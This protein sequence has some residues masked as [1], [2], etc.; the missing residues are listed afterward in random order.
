MTTAWIYNGAFA[1]LCR[2]NLFQQ[3]LASSL[4]TMKSTSALC[5]AL[6]GLSHAYP[7][8]LEHLEQAGAGSAKVKRQ[9][10]LSTP[11]FDAASQYVDTTGSHA[12]QAPG[13][14]DQ[15]GPCP[16]LN[17]LANVSDN[18]DSM[19]AQCQLTCI[20]SAWLLAAQWYRNDHSIHRKHRQGYVA[21]EDEASFIRNITKRHWQCSAWESTFPPFL[22]YT[23]QP[24]MAMASNGRL[25]DRTAV[26]VSQ[27]CWASPRVYQ[28]LT[29]STR[30]TARPLV[31]IC[32]NV[33]MLSTS[34]WNYSRS[35]MTLVRR[36]T[37]MTCNCSRTAA[38]PVPS[39]VRMKTLTASS[40]L[41]PV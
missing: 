3:R 26:S 15:R 16:G 30:E 7:N 10:P 28:A 38:L 14:T 5:L 22:P 31:A 39:S 23:A 12:F 27:T 34:I 24:S 17:A 41:S 6:A 19:V 1:R 25:A 11:P 37:T 32:I 29:T 18:R 36:R 20:C 8:I 21:A 4:A 2:S 9:T 35:C 13:P 40:L 33:A